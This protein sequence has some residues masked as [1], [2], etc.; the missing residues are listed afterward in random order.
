MLQLQVKDELASGERVHF[1][2][3]NVIKEPFI[4]TIGFF[5]KWGVTHPRWDSKQLSNR[6]LAK[7]GKFDIADLT[8]CHFY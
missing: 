5:A 8:Q 4:G 2:R 1:L 7:N 6:S 3:D